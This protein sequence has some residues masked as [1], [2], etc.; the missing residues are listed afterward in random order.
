MTN[1]KTTTRTATV[2]AE[3]NPLAHYA[4]YLKAWPVKFAGPKPTADQFN[5]AHGFGARAGTKVALAIAM[6]LRN[7]GAT[8]GQVFNIVGA[9]QLN[10]M[11]ALIEAGQAVRL[12]MPVNTQGHTVYKLALAPKKA[13]KA[14]PAKT[15]KA[16]PAKPAK[17]ES[18]ATPTV[19][20][21]N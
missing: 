19:D 15:A 8:Q 4:S 10:K 7:D 13:T 11:R 18:A 20:A 5:Q 16:K 17:A 1:T 3:G 6:Y 2:A 12:P 21:A 9:P 14:K